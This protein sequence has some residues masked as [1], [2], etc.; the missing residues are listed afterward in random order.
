MAREKI[1]LEKPPCRSI[2]FQLLTPAPPRVLSSS[3]PATSEVAGVAR[4]GRGGRADGAGTYDGDHFH[5]PG[6][7]QDLG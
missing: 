7:T 5:G 1:I 2:T 4:A 3:W 6:V